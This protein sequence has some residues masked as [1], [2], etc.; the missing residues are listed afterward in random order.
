MALQKVDPTEHEI[1]VSF[2][3]WC[4]LNTGVYPELKIG[5][6]VP[7]G[8]KRHIGVAKKLKAEGVKP[9]IPDWLLPVR[10]GPYIGLAIEFKARRG[11]LTDEQRNM[12][13]L[14]RS[15]GWQTHV[16]RDWEQAADIVVMYLNQEF[17]KNS[18]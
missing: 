9:G 14:L 5:F 4:E 6:A 15:Y 13:Q 16:C 18:T 8:G 11:Q 12:L 17:I 1:Q 3:E 7:N 2:V 10:K